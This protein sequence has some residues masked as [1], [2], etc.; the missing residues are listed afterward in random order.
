MQIGEKHFYFDGT[1][2]GMY[3][4]FPVFMPADAS[5]WPVQPGTTG[6]SGL[7]ARI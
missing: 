6:P 1:F 5:L 3:H 2:S 4:K 7:S